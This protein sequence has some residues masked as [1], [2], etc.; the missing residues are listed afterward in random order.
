[1]FKEKYQ[2]KDS[3][4]NNPL[5]SVI[6]PVYNSASTLSR[7]ICSVLAQTFQNYEIMLVDD[8]STDNIS[9]VIKEFSDSRLHYIRHGNNLGEA[10]A[11][12]T[13]IQAARGEFIAF[14]DADDEWF[15]E[16]LKIQTE[17][18]M[19]IAAPIKA[20]V[21]SALIED[22]HGRIIPNIHSRPS[23]WYREIMLGG[24]LNPGDTLMVSKKAFEEVGY[25]DIDLPR[26]TDWDW[27][28]RY[29]KNDFPLVTIDKPLA[30][31]YRFSSPKASSVEQAVNHFL[32]KYSYEFL[33]KYGWYG[34]KAISKRW[35]DV[36]Y[37]Y[38]IEHNWGKGVKFFLKAIIT[39]PFQSPGFYIRIL[40]GILGTDLWS[41]IGRWKTGFV[42]RLKNKSS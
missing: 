40:D 3:L 30:K 35:T 26:Y 12:T 7:A 38:F 28:L 34:R 33:S 14:L 2:E 18:L 25:Y 4:A 5:V 10:A 36:S 22:Q 8:G 17:E 41:T 1:M 11:R 32:K 31:V 19:K 6:I 27:L 16:K 21:V 42:N 13:G 29:V 39:Y 15:P 37:Y 20:C 24:G 23:S 9:E